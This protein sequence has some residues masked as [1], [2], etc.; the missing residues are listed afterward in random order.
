MEIIQKRRLPGIERKISEIQPENDV[1]VRILGTVIGTG[2]G[3]LMVDD[4]SGRLEILFDH[5][6]A[7]VSEG[8][9]VRIITRILPL[10]DGFECRGECIQLLNEFNVN[11]YN[12][13]Q[14]IIKGD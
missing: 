5:D 9:L 2:Q 11:L 3:S 8:Q 4:G 6:P 12:K 1:R 7:Y 10:I 14:K 13:A